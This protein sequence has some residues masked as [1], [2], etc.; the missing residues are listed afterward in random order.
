MY[1]AR[2]GY[3]A[4]ACYATMLLPLALAQAPVHD[5]VLV[6]CIALALVCFWKAAHAGPWSSQWWWCAAAGVALGVS[7]LG[8]GLPGVAITGVAFG[9]W[10][11]AARRLR[12]SLV[13]GGV[14]ALVVAATVAAPWYLAMDRANP[15]YFHY[16]FVERHLLGFSTTTQ[17][18]GG[19]AWWYYLPI[20]LGGSLPWGLYLVSLRAQRDTD[21]AG[22]LLAWCWLVGGT[23][24]LSLS[25]SK[26]VT[27][28]WPVFPAVAMLASRAWAAG[29][30]P[31]WARAAHTL[32][33]VIMVPMAAL[34]AVVR[35][36]VQPGA[37]AW[38][39]IALLAVAWLVAGPHRPASASNHEV[40]AAGL[41]AGSFVIAMTVIMPLVASTLSAR[42]LARHLNGRG[43]LPAHVWVLDERIGSLLFY[44]DVSHRAGLQ[45]GRVENVGTDRLLSMRQPPEDTVVA[46]PHAALVRLSERLDLTRAPRVRVGH[47]EVFSAEAV[48]AAI[49]RTVG[50]G[51]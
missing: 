28:V 8:K 37:A 4:M 11:L 49:V 7:I 34:A 45:P 10:L 25:G 18:H 19:R 27:Y 6:P 35:F 9:L 40:L 24:F 14:L 33:G 44:L 26:M 41:T 21:R 38:I 32:L 51:R 16:Y 42:D 43:P 3:L 1:G 29:L 36:G 47:Y 2:R 17:I 15:G 30:P 23:V 5:V 13:A 22:N 31:R 12:L 50:T 39:A 20:V 48:H 46:V